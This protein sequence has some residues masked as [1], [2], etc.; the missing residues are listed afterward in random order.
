VALCRSGA[1]PDPTTSRWISPVASAKSAFRGLQV[2]KGQRVP[3]DLPVQLDPPVQP[4]Q[5]VQLDPRGLQEQPDLPGSLVRLAPP[6]PQARQEP[7]VLLVP[8]ARQEPPVL[9]VP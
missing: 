4:E 1:K 6:E 5:P 8:Q 2:L 3:P 9:L 7:P